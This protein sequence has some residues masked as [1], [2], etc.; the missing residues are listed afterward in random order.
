MTSFLPLL[1]VVGCAPPDPID[2]ELIGPP[3]IEVLFPTPGQ[4]LTLNE[5]CEIDTVIVV[6]TRGIVMTDFTEG[7]ALD[8]QQG[9]WHGGPSLDDGFCRSFDTFCGPGGEEGYTSPAFTSGQSA[10]IR[11]EL[12]ANDHRPLEVEDQV[13][14][15]VMAPEG[16]ECP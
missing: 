13:E 3:A 1:F 7:P 16:V 8:D 15:S 11:A 9:H 5:R 12:V 2:P 10:T 6:D 14:V 4:T